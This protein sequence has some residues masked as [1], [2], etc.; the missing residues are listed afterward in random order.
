[1]LGGWGAAMLRPYV[2]WHSMRVSGGLVEKNI[3][4]CLCGVGG[5]GSSS[6][7]AEATSAAAD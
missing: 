4:D 7:C 6:W 5:D 2:F 3:G 1:M